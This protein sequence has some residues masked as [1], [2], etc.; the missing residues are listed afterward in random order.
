MDLKAYWETRTITVLIPPAVLHQVLRE[1]SIHIKMS[2]ICSLFTQAVRQASGAMQLLASQCR[3]KREKIWG[4]S[5]ISWSMHVCWKWTKRC[6]Q[7]Q[8]QLITTV[9]G[10]LQY[11]LDGILGAGNLHCPIKE[12]QPHLLNPKE[13]YYQCKAHKIESIHTPAIVHKLSVK[14]ITSKYKVNITGG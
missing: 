1:I 10:F 7:R 2:L 11:S 9:D 14:A 12:W 6:Q 4:G 5:V 13:F 3:R 8:F